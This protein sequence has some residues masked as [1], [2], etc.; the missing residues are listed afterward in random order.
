MGN[1]VS[2]TV[3]GRASRSPRMIRTCRCSMCCAT[4]SRCTGRVRL[5]PR[6]VRRLHRPCRRQGGAL[7]RHAA[8]RGHAG[9]KVV[10]LEGLGTP[11]KPHPVQTAFIDEQA[12]QC[13][14]CIN[15]MIMQSAALPGDEHEAERGRDQAGARQQPLPLRHA[16]AHR[17]RGQARRRQA[18]R[19][20]SHERAC[21]RIAPRPAEGAAAR[22]L[23]A[24]RL[25]ASAR[26]AARRPPAAKPLCLDEV[27]GFLAIDADGTRDGLF[28]QGR[29]RHRRAHRADADR[30][31]GARRAAE[32]GHRRAGRHGADARSGHRPAAACRSRSAA[33]RSARPRRPRAS[34]AR[35]A[36]QLG[37]RPTTLTVED[38]VVTPAGGNGVGYGELVGGQHFTLKLDKERA[39]QGSGGLHDR[40]Q[41]GAAAR[42]SRQGHR[43]LHLHAGLPRARHAARPRRAPAGDGRDARSVDESSVAGYPG[44]RQGRARRQFPRRRRARPNGR[45][46]RRARQL[47]AHWSNWE[48]LPDQAKLWEHVRAHQS[49]RTR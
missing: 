23:S 14:Y 22:S 13:G 44:H 16:S 19:E 25:P 26:Q 33:C 9:Q 20:A 32:P 24:S 38:G 35:A 29:S 18:R 15:G 40:R 21:H 41:A 49:R 1:P 2:L 48:G 4:I 37:V 6:P 46:S 39:A 8:L 30:R 34:A 10:T 17:A 47:K 36:Q 11:E 28:R 27:D 31:R 42:H 5:R 7:L 3:N 12:V 43:P 45:R